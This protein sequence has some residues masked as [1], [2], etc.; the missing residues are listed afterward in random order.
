MD[1]IPDVVRAAAAA[2]TGRPPEDFTI[3]IDF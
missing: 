2:L 1:D 3:S